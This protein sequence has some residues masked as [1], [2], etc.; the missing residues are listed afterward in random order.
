MAFAPGARLGRALRAF[1]ADSQAAAL[2]D[3]MYTF[4]APAWRNLK[5]ISGR[6]RDWGI[7]WISK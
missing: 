3:V 7:E 1:T 5:G 6:W 2:R 4:E